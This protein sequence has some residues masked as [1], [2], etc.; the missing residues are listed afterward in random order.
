MIARRAIAALAAALAWA[1]SAP[2]RAQTVDG[3]AVYRRCAVCHQP[4]RGG[5]PGTF[6]PLRANVA[7]AAARPDGRS[8]LALVVTR[9]LSGPITIDGKP[10]RGAMPAQAGLTDAEAAAVLNH[11]LETFGGRLARPFTAAEVGQARKAG[12]ALD[13]VAVGRLRPGAAK[14]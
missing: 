3:A 2:A 4:D 13:P 1:A 12:A 10:Y 5:L 11:L 9:G 7:T 6:P 8:Y 14:K